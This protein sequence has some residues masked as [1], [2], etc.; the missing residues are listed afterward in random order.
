VILVLFDW[1]GA[2]RIVIC[3]SYYQAATFF[4]AMK[5]RSRNTDKK[6]PSPSEA[7]TTTASFFGDTDSIM[8][9]T[10]DITAS[11]QNNTTRRKKRSPLQKLKSLHKNSSSLSK[12]NSISEA[13]KRAA[14]RNIPPSFTTSKLSRLQELK[15]AK[16][17]AEE[18]HINGSGSSS[19]ASSSIRTTDTTTSIM[20]VNGIEVQP[21]DDEL[22][23]KNNMSTFITSLFIH[24]TLLQLIPYFNQYKFTLSIVLTTLQITSFHTLLNSIFIY[25]FDNINYGQLNIVKNLEYGKLLYIIE[26][27]KYTRLVSLSIGLISVLIGLGYSLFL[28]VGIK[29]GCHFHFMSS[30]MCSSSM[31]DK[32]EISLSWYEQIYKTSTFITTRLSVFTL[33]V[34]LLGYVLLPNKKKKKKSTNHDKKNNKKRRD[35]NKTLQTMTSVD[36]ESE[37][38]D[39]DEGDDSCNNSNDQQ[40]RRRKHNNGALTSWS[41]SFIIAT[42]IAIIFYCSKGVTATSSSSSSLSP[43]SFAKRKKSILVAGSLNADTFLP[44]HR[45]PSSGENLTLLPGHQPL[46]DVPGGKGCNQAIACAKL[47]LS[48]FK[49]KKKRAVVSFLGQ[50]GNDAAASILKSALLDNNVYI[51]THSGYSKVYPS[52]RGYVMLVPKT[53]EVSAVVSGGSNLY[54][55]EN[56]GVKN[57]DEETDSA[58]SRQEDLLT[59]QDIQDLV[60]EHS[61]LLLQCEVPNFVNVRLA[62]AAR[63]VNI[64]VIVD[65]CGEDRSMSRD[66]LECCDY[67]IP[68]ETELERLTNS[69]QQ[70]DSVELSIDH[71]DMLEQI[72]AKIGPSLDLTSII[73]SVKTLQRN[74]ASNVLVTLGSKGSILIKKEPHSILYQPACSLPSRMAVVDETGAGDCYRAGF[75]TALMEHKEVNDDVLQKC[76]K[77]ASAAGALA[78]TRQGAVPSIPSREEVEELLN[79]ADSSG[80]RTEKAI[81]RGGDTSDDD[82]FPFMFGSRLNS[83]KDR[84]D[85]VDSPMKTPRDYV[86][87][88]ATIQGLGCVD[89]NYPQHFGDYWTPTEAKKALDE[90]GLIAGAVC[91]RYPSKFARGAMNHPDAEMRREAIE[92]TKQAAEAARILGCNE[93]VVWSAYDGYD[94]PFQV[95]YQ[96]KWK[97]IVS[98]FRECCDAFPDI[99]WSLEFKPTDENT[100]F[101]TVPSTGA[102]MLLVKEIDRPNM[103]L[104]LDMGHMLMAGENPAQSIQMVGSKLFGIQLNDGYTR[105]AAEDG[106]MFGSI[107][108]SIALEAMYQLREINFSGHL[109]FDTFPQRTDPVKEAEYNIRRVKKYWMAVNN[110]DSNEIERIA[111]EHDAI[112]ALELVNDALGRR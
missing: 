83:M 92:I 28:N 1:G 47:S 55:W 108:P 75:V 69:F 20:S 86:K 35:E 68:N 93:V 80:K 105:L 10:N 54:G 42:T 67:L 70:E 37:E 106:M 50:F 87:R 23:L 29:W 109:Y 18:R 81:P 102:A 41:V 14:Q 24:T 71:D 91:L 96:E 66:L 31:S 101:F 82:S 72:Q 65:V 60:S 112:G 11:Q 104:T 15:E 100:R 34:L 19:I 97:Q 3:Y 16:L 98:A 110:M 46:V 17:R 61:L 6:S 58:S 74:G 8:S 25:T 48:L 32:H 56:W 45:F 95:S 5:L 39:D 52:G 43:P 38:D 57:N 79:T 84:L 77:F 63:K 59:D 107:H 22:L 85:L 49:E 7:T 33:A 44:I 78:V 51:S 76:M 30:K 111:R 36:E 90:V 53:G 4:V 88:Q 40:Q 12:A 13:R 9:T 62:T 21:I 27:Q 26:V 64:P 99:K 73:K 89:F 94:Y 2:K 103:G